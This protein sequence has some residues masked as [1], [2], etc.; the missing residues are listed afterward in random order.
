[1][2]TKKGFSWDVTG[3]ILSLNGEVV[4]KA[5]E[6][7]FKDFYGNATYTS[8]KYG[9]LFLSLIKKNGETAFGVRLSYVQDQCGVVVLSSLG[10]IPAEGTEFQMLEDICVWLG[11]SVIIVTGTTGMFDSGVWDKSDW[12]LA[13]KTKNVRMG[14]VIEI[15]TKVIDGGD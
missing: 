5:T 14:S 4:A 1:M 7:T 10:Y 8:Y 11:Y 12:K 3:K 6:G 13:R 9:N 2:A 15:R